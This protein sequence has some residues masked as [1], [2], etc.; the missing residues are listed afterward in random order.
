MATIKDCLNKIKTAIY[1]RE[2]R[3]SIVDSIEQCYKDATGHPERI[4]AGVNEIKE[5]DEK[6]NLLSA[7]MDTFTTLTEGS[8]T[9]DAELTDI[10]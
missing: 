2:V 1:G 9:G 8:T 5:M 7:R 3:Q 10:R 4:S 6:A